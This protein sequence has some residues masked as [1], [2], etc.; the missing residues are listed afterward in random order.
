MIMLVAANEDADLLLRGARMGVRG[1]VTMRSEVCDFVRAV[2]SL[3]HGAVA[4]P[5]DLMGLVWDDLITWSDD[6]SEDA[7]LARLSNRE[8]EVLRLLAEGGNKQSIATIC[9]SVP[10]RSAPTCSTS[11]PNSV[12]DPSWRR[13]PS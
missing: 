7:R 3:L 5:P 4:I 9:T 13:F 11:S 8:R 1:Y 6:E 12:C 10:T 2:E